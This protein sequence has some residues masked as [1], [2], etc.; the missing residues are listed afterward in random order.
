MS[1]KQ[2]RHLIIGVFITL[3]A[4]AGGY[5]VGV[6]GFVIRKGNF[7][8][9]TITREVPATKNIDFSLFWNVWDTVSAQ[10]VDKAKV[11]PAQMVYGAIKGMVA[12]IGDPYTIFLTPDENKVSQ[13]DLQGNFDGV[14]IQIGFRDGQL[15]VVAPLPNTPAEKAGVRAGDYIIEIKDEKKNIQKSTNGMT[16]P[17]AVQLIRGQ[18]GTKVTL[19]LI[20]ED[21]QKPIVV[22]LIRDN[23]EVPSVVLANIEG[24]NNIAHVKLLKFGGDTKKE[25]DRVVAELNKRPE[26][27]KIILDLRNNPGGYLQSSVDIAADFLPI[28][29]VVVVEEESGGGKHEFKTTTAPRLAKYNLVILANK[30]SAS[31]SEILAGA[32]RDQRKV[33]LVGDNTFGKGSVQEPQQLEGGAGLHITIAKWLTPSGAWIN[34]KGLAPDISIEDNADTVEDEQ[35]KK[36]VEIISGISQ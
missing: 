15:A 31:A 14:G 13:E 27:D 20:R 3:F 10:Y 24:Q 18:K 36:A 22:D 35:L 32:L 23:I 26:I 4:F 29:S 12:S 11:V 1:K 7:P 21:E 9:V 16:L 30:G 8:T 17:D 2:A 25:W 19:T 6:S 34:E 5:L 28:G 33:K